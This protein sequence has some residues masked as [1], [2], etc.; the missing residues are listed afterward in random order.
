MEANGFRFWIANQFMDC[1]SIEPP[2]FGRRWRQLLFF[3]LQIVTRM[4]GQA[5]LLGEPMVQ[6]DHFASHRAKR[7]RRRADVCREVFLTGRTLDFW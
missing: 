4:D 1:R 3:L 6:V 2:L 7:H 5:D